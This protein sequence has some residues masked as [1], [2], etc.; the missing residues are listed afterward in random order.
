MFHY[1][2]LPTLMAKRSRAE[3]LLWRRTI[4]MTRI[5]CTIELSFVYVH[6][7]NTTLNVIWVSQLNFIFVYGMFYRAFKIHVNL[8]PSTRYKF[9]TVAITTWSE[10]TFQYTISLIISIH[11]LIAFTSSWI[12]PGFIWIWVKTSCCH[13]YF[14]FQKGN[15]INS[16]GKIHSVCF[17]KSLYWKCHMQFHKT[18]Y[19]HRHP[20]PCHP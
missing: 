18:S 10:N 17:A 20:P 8:L 2:G 13:I 9:P 14:F 7:S 15:N 4:K 12:N 5:Y 16:E 6:L 3:L 11:L 1:I 19:F